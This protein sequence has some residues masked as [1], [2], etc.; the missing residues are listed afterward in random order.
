MPAET[1]K[2]RAL[3]ARTHF[4]PGFGQVHFDPDSKKEAVRFPAMPV[5]VIDLLVSWGWISDDVEESELAAAPAASRASRPRK[6][7]APAASASDEA[8]VE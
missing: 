8:P 6:P 3:S 2:V 1:R 5:D 4:V 7:A